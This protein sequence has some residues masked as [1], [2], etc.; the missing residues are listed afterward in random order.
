L[1]KTP[2][3]H[4]ARMK[5]SEKDTA[6]E[7]PKEENKNTL[8]P[9]P[10]ARIRFGIITILVGFMIVLLGAKPE[11]FGLDRSPVVGFVQIA[12]MIV[13]V[14][15]ICLAGYIVVK[16]LWRRTEPS[17]AADI[18]LRLVSTGYVITIFSGMA[19]VFGF[20]SQTLPNVPFFGVWQ[21]RGMEIGLGI[22]TIGFIMMFPYQKPHSS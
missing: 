19:D 7:S 14:G 13:G 15:I 9:L 21:A 5:T 16:A 8:R 1:E 17:I 11:L 12:T 22:I 18:G 4:I 6:S 20:G 2:G 3:E 10:R